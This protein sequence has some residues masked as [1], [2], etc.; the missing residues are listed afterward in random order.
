M[1]KDREVI[2]VG[3]GLA[4]LFSAYKLASK[5]TRVT[6]LST[7]RIGN[8][9]TALAVGGLNVVSQTADSPRLHAEETVKV[10]RLLANQRPVLQMCRQA[11]SLLEEFLKLGVEFPRNRTTS[12]L[13]VL[14]GGG[15]HFCRK[16]N[17]SGLALL[18]VLED[19]L[20]K[21]KENGRVRL[22][23]GYHFLSLLIHEG[24]CRGVYVLPLN[25]EHSITPI[26]S[27]AVIMATGGCASLYRHSTSCPQ[28][29]GAAAGALIRQGVAY[30][31]GEFIQFHPTTTLDQGSQTRLLSEALRSGGARLW[32]ERDGKR[33]YFMEELSPSF[34]NLAPRDLISRTMHNLSTQG[35]C[36]KF[37]LDLSPVPVELRERLLRFK[38]T[39][40]SIPVR[41][42][43][44]FSMGGI[45]VDENGM[46]SLPGLFAVGECDH[47]FHGA[48]RLGGNALLACAYS[49]WRVAEISLTHY[50]QF[51]PLVGSVPEQVCEEGRQAEEQLQASLLDKRGSENLTTLVDELGSLM[52][53]YVGVV[54]DNSEL[55][56][57]EHHLQMLDWRIKRIRGASVSSIQSIVKLR[58]LHNS[59]LLAQVITRSALLRNESRGSHFKPLFSQPNDEEWLKTT[60]ATYQNGELEVR[61][62]EVERSVF[63]E[64]SSASL[65]NEK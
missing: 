50:W 35:R 36:Q 64:L 21:L 19:E 2:V 13:I 52:E 33:W 31:N 41:P 56:E 34:G 12:N 9:A 20:N 30:G 44:H 32:G 4:G 45:L 62:Q 3:T 23:Q 6:L 63:P 16:V 42:S 37:Y 29:N 51:L 53:R 10:G 49:A 7:R 54:R 8:S 15:S 61:Y 38:P 39:L 65:N 43:A 24:I 40:S 1:Y 47:E 59:L 58:D 46:S 26:I 11:P 22:L 55:T 18:R 48:N 27:S 28:A 25:G 14:K 57:A 17:V 5:G 60:V